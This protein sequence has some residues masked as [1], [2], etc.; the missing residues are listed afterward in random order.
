MTSAAIAESHR[1]PC[2]STCLR[3]KAEFRLYQPSKPVRGFYQGGPERNYIVMLDGEES[4]RVAFHEY[5]H[6]VLNHTS[7]RLPK[8]FEEGLA[9]FYSTVGL[10]REKL[11]IGKPIPAHV[12]TLADAVWLDADTFAGVDRDSP[13]Y[14]DHDQVGMFYAQSWGLVHMLNLA[15][16]YRE[17]MG[18]Y[19]SQIA[20]G[21]PAGAAFAKA[22][23]KPM[24]AALND[25]EPMSGPAAGLK[26]R[27]RGIRRT[28]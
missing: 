11:I 17:R 3:L 26:Y 4:Y 28:P 12:R 2:A 10:T 8:W 5:I 18:E 19:A 6:L 16:P 24:A 15:P 23:G 14:N 21:V 25:L 13:A 27:W 22:F 1:F 20:D 7:A 9:E